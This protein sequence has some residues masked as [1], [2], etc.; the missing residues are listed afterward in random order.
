M[1]FD[2]KPD[3]TY[4]RKLFREL[5]VREMFHYDYVFDWTVLKYQVCS[6]TTCQLSPRLPRA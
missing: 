1:R 4:L 2:D 6:T 5:F 3:Y